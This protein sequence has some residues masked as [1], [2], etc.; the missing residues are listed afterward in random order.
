MLQL[1]FQHYSR[2]KGRADS[3]G[4][5]HVF[6]GEVGGVLTKPF[7][8]QFQCPRA[9]RARI[10]LGEEQ[11][12]VRL[13][14]LGTILSTWEERHW[15]FRL[16]RIYRETCGELTCHF[17]WIF[18]LFC[19]GMAGTPLKSQKNPE[20]QRVY[21]FI[22][23]QEH[24]TIW[25]L[26]PKGNCVPK[27]TTRRPSLLPE[28]PNILQNVMAALKFSWNGDLKRSGS[29][30]IGTSPE[31]DMALYTLCFLS[32]RGKELCNV[33]SNLGHLGLFQ[34]HRL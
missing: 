7:F 8:S 20:N 13:A 12:G 6:M 17:S 30:L 26:R 32:R 24:L 31:F 9:P 27:T 22:K 14:Q 4:F 2:A 3:S 5:E 18:L 25:I 21:C 1:W 33:S 11:R 16:R 19:E 28:Q 23:F 10:L 34:I 29:M 15:E